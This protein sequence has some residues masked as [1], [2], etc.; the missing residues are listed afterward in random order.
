M[1]RCCA[2]STSSSFPTGP[3]TRSACA[4]SRY[5]SGA[6]GYAGSSGGS[7]TTTRPST[8]PRRWASA[9]APAAAAPPPPPMALKMAGSAAR[10]PSGECA[11]CGGGGRQ[12]LKRRSTGSRRASCGR[13]PRELA[14]LPALTRVD[15]ER[16]ISPCQMTTCSCPSGVSRSRSSATFPSTTPRLRRHAHSHAESST[17]H[18]AIWYRLE[19]AAPVGRRALADHGD[20]AQDE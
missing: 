10:A 3:S 1:G 6:N 8:A 2:S 16:Q 9:A 5:S 12:R 19:A 7:S 15:I 11:T 18:V 20:G 4:A 17:L 14:R 13:R